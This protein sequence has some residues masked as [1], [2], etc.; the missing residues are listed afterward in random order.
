MQ[1]V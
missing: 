1:D